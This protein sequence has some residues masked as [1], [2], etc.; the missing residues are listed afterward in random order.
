MKRT[1]VLLLMLTSFFAV[2]CDD[3][4]GDGDGDDENTRQVLIF[5]PNENLNGTDTTDLRDSTGVRIFERMMNAVAISNSGWDTY[6]WESVNTDED[7]RDCDDAYKVSYIERVADNRF[8]AA[9]ICLDSGNQA[10]EASDRLERLRGL[11]DAVTAD[12]NGL[13]GTAMENRNSISNGGATCDKYATNA[14]SSLTPAVD[15][16]MGEIYVFAGELGDASLVLRCHPRSDLVGRDDY[17][18]TE[19]SGRQFIKETVDELN[20]MSMTDQSLISSGVWNAYRFP[21]LGQP[22]TLADPPKL[23]YFR[24][25]DDGRY[26]IGSGIYLDRNNPNAMDDDRLEQVRSRVSQAAG[27]L[28][29]KEG[30]ELTGVLEST[31]F[32]NIATVD[33]SDMQAYIFVWENR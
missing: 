4:D 20:S 29:E 8:V 21:K 18:L 24:R 22:D 9:G 10:A 32:T 5:H 11:V 7:P 16:E 30:S 27:L 26:L 6:R 12:V 33:S 19:D 13:S 3:G 14:L 23:S 15:N 31:E 17:L 25:S 28:R 2:S 1:I